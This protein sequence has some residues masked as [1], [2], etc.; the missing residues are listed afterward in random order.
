GADADAVELLEAGLEH[1]TSLIGQQLG[2]RLEAEPGMGAAGGL[3][4]GLASLCGAKLKRGVDAVSEALGVFARVAAAA[5]V[6]TGEGQIDAQTRFEKG[7]WG[8]GRLA[9]MQKKRV[10]AFAGA[11]A[12]PAS[13]THDAFD[14]VVVV[15][16]E[17]QELPRADEAAALLEGAAK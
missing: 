9:R 6:G 2:R 15:T 14:E 1:L 17:H 7:P 16:P 10:V 3:A 5:I 8:L 12:G 11:V 13:A 4:Y